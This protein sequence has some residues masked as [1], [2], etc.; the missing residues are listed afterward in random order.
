[1]LTCYLYTCYFLF[2]LLLYWLYWCKIGGLSLYS[3]KLQGK[4]LENVV[5]YPQSASMSPHAEAVPSN[6]LTRPTLQ[7]CSSNIHRFL[8]VQPPLVIFC[9]IGNVV[10]VLIVLSHYFLQLR[11]VKNWM[12]SSIIRQI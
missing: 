9:Q 12:Y 1:M 6:S 3:S 7:L 10:L 11:Y 2:P 4:N 8:Q 5:A